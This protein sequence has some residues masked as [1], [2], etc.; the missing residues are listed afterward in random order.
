MTR[1]IGSISCAF[2]SVVRSRRR[3]AMASS[4][5]SGY[6]LSVLIDL[7]HFPEQKIESSNSG[8]VGRRP[9]GMAAF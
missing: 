9:Y 1:L 8:N 3:S 6:P 2:A 4:G 7:L 5:V